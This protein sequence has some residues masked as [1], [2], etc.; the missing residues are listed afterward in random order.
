M[1]LNDND[2]FFR[3]TLSC[4]DG[5]MNVLLTNATELSGERPVSKWREVVLRGNNV[6]YVRK[7]Q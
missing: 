7:V 5:H 2:S 1:R 4:L 3:G 6:L